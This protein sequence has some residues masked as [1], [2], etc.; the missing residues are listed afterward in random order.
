MTKREAF[1]KVLNALKSEVQPGV[2]GS[3]K[4][5]FL[6]GTLKENTA[7]TLLEENG[8]RKVQDEDWTD[9]ETPAKA[10]K[11]DW[12]RTVISYDG[13]RGKF[14]TST[15]KVELH[16]GAIDKHK[17]MFKNA[18]NPKVVLDLDEQIEYVNEVLKQ[19]L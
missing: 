6:E 8:F 13:F 15:H 7:N 17:T 2:L 18:F 14:N 9:A 1:L 16:S 5:R 11:D 4:K 12:Y 10:E 3:L 19:I